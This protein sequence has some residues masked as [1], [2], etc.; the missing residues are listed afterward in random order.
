[1]ETRNELEGTVGLKEKVFSQ[2]SIHAFLSRLI[3]YAGLFPPASLLL[4]TSIDNYTAYRT[5]EDSW[6]L[7]RFIIPAGQ[8]DGLHSY[9][10][11]FSKGKPLGISAIG[12]R[13]DHRETCLEGLH[14]DLENIVSFSKDHVDLVNID[15]FEMPLPPFAAHRE[16]LNVIAA[17]TAKHGLQTFCE[18]TSP[19]NGDWE[20]HLVGTLDAIVAHNAESE[21]VLGFK[22]RTGGVTAAAFPTPEQ[23]AA[24]LIGC[25]DRG[26]ALKFTAGLH[27]PIRMYREEVGTKMHGYLNVFAAGM[28]AHVYNL[29][30]EETAEILADEES[31]SFSFTTKGLSWRNLI[32]PVAEMVRLRKTAFCSYGS[33]SFDEPRDDL[34]MLQIDRMEE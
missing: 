14:Q 6:M 1:M 20:H 23:V 16:L 12:R 5:C 4:E 31:V 18:M 22:L 3:D 7:G 15:V 32:V 13:S 24:V 8:L 33:C 27:H 26:I 11:R 34:R 19:L 2:T 17:E 25:R 30:R 21:A 29:D 10:L 28:L 9:V